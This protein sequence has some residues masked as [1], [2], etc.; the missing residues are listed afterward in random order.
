MKRSQR[1]ENLMKEKNWN[2]R[3]L[4]KKSGV[5]YTTIRSMLDRNLERASID[6]VIKIAKALEVST[7]YLSSESDMPSNLEEVKNMVRVPVLGTISCGDPILAEENIDSYKH[8]PADQVPSGEVFTLITK[9]N[10]M[11]P[12]IPVGSEV[13]VRYQ[14]EVENGEIAAVLVNGDTEATLKRVKKQKDYIILMPDNNNYDP[15]FVDK[16][17][18]ARILGKAVSYSHNL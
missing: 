18:P 14:S 9:G 13:L 2:V 16:E 1:I 4:A 10:S 17:N 3:E 8:M 6:N 12:T 15:I 7:E 11:E 5:P